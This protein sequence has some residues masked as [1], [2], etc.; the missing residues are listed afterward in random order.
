MFEALLYILRFL[1]TTY[2]GAL[3]WFM[4]GIYMIYINVKRPMRMRVIDPFQAAINGWV[5]AIGALLISIAIFY[6][7]LSGKL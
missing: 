5:G 7:K 4:L 2:C 1:V 6:F 3:I